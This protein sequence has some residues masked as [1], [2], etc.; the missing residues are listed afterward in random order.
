MDMFDKIREA[1][2]EE[3]SCSAHDLDHTKRVYNLCLKLAE[4][5]NVD[6]EV[7]RAAALLHD[8]GRVREDSDNTGK[9]DHALVSTEMA[10]PIL[11]EAGF[12]ED[13][14]P[15]VRDC[16]TSHRFRSDKM[17]RTPEAEILFD[18]DKLDIMGAIGIARAFVWVGRNNARIY[19]KPDS[20]EQY[21]KENLSGS[22]NGRVQD[23]TKHS[24]QIEFETKW[25]GVEERLHTEKA[26]KICRERFAFVEGFMQRLEKEVKGEI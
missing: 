9:T 17:P 18:A 25:K 16:I 23:K 1:V 3:L 11:K 22:L 13:K 14:I 20:I 7:V 15:H 19:R 24:P 8:I 10:G 6:L 4:D 12:P 26:R 21:A 5:Q 2:R